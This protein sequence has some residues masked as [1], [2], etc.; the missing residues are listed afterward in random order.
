MPTE[1]LK[2]KHGNKI[3]EIRTSGKDLVIYDKHGNKLGSYDGK[4][5]YDKH[6]KKVGSG[7][8]LISLLTVF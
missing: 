6:H 5:T 8:L 7:N 2:D 3:G 4:Y 1:V